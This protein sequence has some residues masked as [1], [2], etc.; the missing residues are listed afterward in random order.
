MLSKTNTIIVYKMWRMIIL[1]IKFY[2]RGTTLIANIV[3]EL[4]HHSAEYIRQKIDN[5][6][7][8]STNKNI[9]FDFSKLSFMDSSGIGVIMGRYKNIQR[10]NG[11]IAIVNTNIQIDRIL[12]MAGIKKIIP[13]YDKSDAA[14][15]ALQQSVR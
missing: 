3:G 11:K 6:M 8:K 10:L 13:V 15:E 12:E 5:E 2:N 4:D 9:I 14:I 1:Q 7:I